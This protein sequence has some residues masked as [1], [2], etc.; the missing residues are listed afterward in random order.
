MKLVNARGERKLE[1]KLYY[2]DSYKQDFTTK[3]IKQDYDKDG[4]LYVVLNETAFY[5]TG[6]GQPYDTGTLNDIDVINVEEVHGEILHFI[7]EKLHTEEV[8]GKINWER[9]FDHMQQHTAQHILSAA[10]GIILT[11]LRSD[12]TLEKK[13]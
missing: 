1:H 13:R 3:I 10:F 5:P 4:N 6:G 2:T 9:R 7:V 11:Y 8:E 12:S